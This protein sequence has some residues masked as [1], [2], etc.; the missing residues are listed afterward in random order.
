MVVNTTRGPRSSYSD[1]SCDQLSQI[2]PNAGETFVLGA[3]QQRGIHLQRYQVQD[4]IR[5]VDPLSPAMSYNVSCP[6]TLW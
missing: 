1:V 4:A 6:N 3:L 5:V 2:L